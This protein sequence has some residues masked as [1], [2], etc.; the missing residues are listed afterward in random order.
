MDPAELLRYAVERRAS[1]VHVKAGNVPFIRVDG[2]LLPTPFPEVTDEDAGRFA[3]ALMPPHKAVEFAETREADFAYT[4]NGV[5]RFR[6]NVLRQSDSVGL[7]IRWVSPEDLTFDEL[8]LP[9]AIGELAE[10]KRG[11]IL[12]T[13]PTG[14]GKTTT[15][16]T[17]LGFINR[18]RR[19]H[20]VTIE[21]PIEVVF[22]DAMSVIRQRE[23]GRDTLS[24]AAALRQALRQD[25]DVIFL[26]EIRDH[27]TALA[28]IQ[29]AQTGHLV[30]ST[31]HTID[32]AETISRIVEMFPPVQQNQVRASVAGALRGVVSQRLLERADGLGRVPAV[33][34][35]LNT[36][37]IYDRVLDPELEPSIH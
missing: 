10:T 23:V 2:E 13:G 6:V 18:T 35:M 15:I 32:A 20:I 27:E 21:D 1:D 12:V 33:E 30:L 26:G 8:A 34:V 17:I 22:N 37:R 36:G 7:A 11:L 29:A 9:P 14:A 31:M 19:A 4:L 3:D 25:P 24:Y 16:A 28:A 5:G